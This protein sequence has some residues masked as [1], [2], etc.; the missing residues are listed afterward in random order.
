MLG[1]QNDELKRK[2][3]DR[4]ATIAN[5]RQRNG[6]LQEKLSTVID[7]NSKMANALCEISMKLSDKI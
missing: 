2:L 6:G 3:E 5:L 1:S 4:E 7:S